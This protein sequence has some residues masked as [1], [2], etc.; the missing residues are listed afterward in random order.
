MA[1]PAPGG[2]TGTD[3]VGVH[4]TPPAPPG[5]RD[6]GWGPLSAPWLQQW[7][8]QGSTCRV[9]LWDGWQ[10]DRTRGLGM[11]QGPPSSA[12]R[13]AGPG[14]TRA[15]GRTGA[16]GGAVM[17]PA[18]TRGCT[19]AGCHRSW[20]EP[21][22]RKRPGH[23]RALQ[24]HGAWECSWAPFVPRQWAPG[25]GH[26][27]GGSPRP[28]PPPRGQRS[29]ADVSLR[30]KGRDRPG[31]GGG[32]GKVR[33]ASRC[34]R[35]SCPGTGPLDV[36]LVPCV[37]RAAPPRAPG[38]LRTRVCPRRAARLRAH[39]HR[40]AGPQRAPS[41]RDFPTP[42][43][44]QRPCSPPAP[45]PDL[46]TNPP[47]AIKR[48]PGA[49]PASEPGTAMKASL[50]F[51]LACTAV[52]AVGARADSPEEPKALVQKVQ[53]LAQKATAMAKDAFSRVRE[54]EAAQQAR[55]WLSDN[56]ELAKQRLVWLK[57]QLAELLKKT[58]PA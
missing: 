36:T 40:H 15:Q 38:W 14:R 50:L 55:Q 8:W 44:T 57:E 46:C 9:W 18:D 11:L 22:H 41:P 7:L 32:S 52:L 25:S 10:R 24:P 47:E 17:E 4:G 2:V 49:A 3:G 29:R 26:T 30:A 27:P 33:R 1:P 51:L 58:P 56:A 12:T 19:Q 5:D 37:P 31:G 6:L 39:P 42:G 45:C 23:C 13:W 48:E 54:S 34:P 28:S 35:A 20:K 43:W 16:Q 21:W 53:E